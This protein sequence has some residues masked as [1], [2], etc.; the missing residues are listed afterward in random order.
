MRKPIGIKI[1]GITNII[2]GISP[3]LFLSFLCIQ[4]FYLVIFFFLF[5][6]F[7]WVT[8]REFKGFWD[9][10]LLSVG[11]RGCIITFCLFSFLLF[12][13]GLAMIKG[14]SYG[15]KLAI[16]SV[17]IIALSWIGYNV[18][19]IIHTHLYG[20]LSI[21]ANLL[22]SVFLISFGLLIYVFFLIKYLMRPTIKEQ[23]DKEGME[24]STVLK[25]T[26]LTALII[27]IIVIFG[28]LLIPLL[29]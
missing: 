8:D 24:S 9:W 2:L 26:I 15:R 23:F 21:N 28:C 20:N 7:G 12:Q 5:T 14:K 16:I 22:N 13:S 10:F 29:R 6:F 3:F 11:E 4:Q 25:R 19:S 1:F 17:S 27:L 18:L